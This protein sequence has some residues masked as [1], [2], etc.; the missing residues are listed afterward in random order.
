MALFLVLFVISITQERTTSNSSCYNAY[1]QPDKIIDLESLLG[2]KNIGCADTSHKDGRNEGNPEVLLVTIEPYSS[3]PKGYACQG[4]IG[5]SKI[6]P[7]HIKVDVY[8]AS[9]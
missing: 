3:G 1:I 4:L 2:H 8:A 5:P 9:N 7:E 6:A